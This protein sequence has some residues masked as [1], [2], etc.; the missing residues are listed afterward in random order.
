MLVKVFIENEANTNRKNHFNEKT[1]EYLET[2]TITGRYP[3]PYGFILHTTGGDGD[4]LDCFVITDKPLKSR[5]IVEC[6][7]VAILEETESSE[8]YPG[9][10]EE[11]NVVLAVL[12]GEPVQIGEEMKAR[13]QEFVVHI[14]DHIPGKKTIVGSFLGR[15]EAIAQVQRCW[16]RESLIS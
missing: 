6:E 12:K 13:L 3:F 1:L 4:N 8:E 9:V 7:P 15:E 11:D 16:D 14:F 2:T 5:Q 10:M